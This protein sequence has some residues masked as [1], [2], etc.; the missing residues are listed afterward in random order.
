MRA[1]DFAYW[2]QGFFEMTDSKTLTEKQVQMVKEHLALV[3]TKTTGEKKSTL[4]TDATTKVFD[5]F[6]TTDKTKFC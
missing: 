2:L 3:F 5:K 1:E 6:F 4:L